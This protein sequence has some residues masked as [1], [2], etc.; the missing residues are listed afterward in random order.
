MPSHQQ[1]RHFGRDEPV[2]ILGASAEVC[3]QSWH[4]RGA[5]DSETERY[6]EDA[7]GSAAVVGADLEQRSLR[8][9]FDYALPALLEANVARD[10]EA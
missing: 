2:G 10:V 1:D 7:V 3:L 4:D 8:E 9:R 5:V 6:V